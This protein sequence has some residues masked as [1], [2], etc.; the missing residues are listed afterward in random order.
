[1][2]TLSSQPSSSQ[3]SSSQPTSSQKP[4]I[5]PVPKRK[6]PVATTDENAAIQISSD[7]DPLYVKT[8]RSHTP[9]SSSSYTDDYF[10]VV[11]PS[12]PSKPKAS[13]TAK[14]TGNGKKTFTP[15]QTQSSAK[16]TVKRRAQPAVTVA[17]G[18]AGSSARPAVRRKRKLEWDD[19]SEDEMFKPDPGAMKAELTRAPVPCV[20]ASPSKSQKS[21]APIGAPSSPASRT[22]SSKRRRITPRDVLPAVGHTSGE[23]ADVEEVPSSVSD[24]QELVL[25]NPEKK[26]DPKEVQATVDSWRRATSVITSTFEHSPPPSDYPSTSPTEPS[27]STDPVALPT[28]RSTAADA[29]M[30]VDMTDAADLL[31]GIGTQGNGGSEY[32]VSQEL[33][34]QSSSSALLSFHEPP[35]LSQ[36]STPELDPFEFRPVT[37]P[38][39]EPLPP[40][41]PTPVALNVETKTAQAIARIKAL[42]EAA[43]REQQD[44]SDDQIQLGDLSD[45]SDLESFDFNLKP[46]R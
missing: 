20:P 11:G 40:L 3:P 1:M 27:P 28:K 16:T 38:P 24:E 19:S 13:T 18:I 37:P 39:A 29:S 32:E 46:T 21:L 10:V 9:I 17:A 4:G 43:V 14:A 25:P 22:S 33:N 44:K 26:K 2:S 34:L 23:D 7:S 35:P 31:Q 15:T 45:D 8:N 30:D 42:A 41:P 5:K 6:G 12:V 36:T